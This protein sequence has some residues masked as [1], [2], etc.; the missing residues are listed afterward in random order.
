MS[1]IIFKK[2]TLLLTMLLLP[3]TTSNVFAIDFSGRA[4]QVSLITN[5][6]IDQVNR[7]GEVPSYLIE[8]VAGLPPD[9]V[10][11]KRFI[12]NKVSQQNRKA[13][14]LARQKEEREKITGNISESVSVD[15][16]RNDNISQISIIDD[17]GNGY[18][19]TIAEINK[20]I[21]DINGKYIVKEFYRYV[22]DCKKGLVCPTLQMTAYPGSTFN[23]PDASAHI[24]T[25]NETIEFYQGKLQSIAIKSNDGLNYIYTFSNKII[26][27]VVSNGT[28]SVQAKIYTNIPDKIRIV[29]ANMP[30]NA[31][32]SLVQIYRERGVT[33]SESAMLEILEGYYND[34]L[35]SKGDTIQS[36]L[37][38]MVADIEVRDAF[39][40]Y[41]RDVAVPTKKERI[42]KPV[43]YY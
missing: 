42:V 16:Y 24:V 32:S 11:L 34:R 3:V 23:L 36:L 10:M 35:I 1:V 2:R 30:V 15:T 26:T 38:G 19:K 39:L 31:S 18:V 9:Y 12:A 21:G 5:N 27:Y 8:E 29:E 17:N 14:L 4:E 6:I 41:C 43:K 33:I 28:S 22:G 7:S 20:L 25:G 37:N 40:L 13:E